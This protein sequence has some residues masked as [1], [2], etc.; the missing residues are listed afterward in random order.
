MQHS[1]SYFISF[2]WNSLSDPVSNRN[3]TKAIQTFAKHSSHGVNA[4]IA[5]VGSTDDALYK[6]IQ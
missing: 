3:A 2:S 6:Y 1:C 4:L 5:L